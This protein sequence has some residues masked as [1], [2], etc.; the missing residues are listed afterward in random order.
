MWKVA[1]R[2]SPAERNSIKKKNSVK[3]F[4]KRKTNEERGP[5]VE[6]RENSVEKLGNYGAPSNQSRPSF[7]HTHAH[8]KKNS[9]KTRYSIKDGLLGSST[10][11]TSPKTR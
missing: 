10:T 8:Q 3:L 5:R 9:V 2:L 6:Y 4:F 11:A 7:P 1:A